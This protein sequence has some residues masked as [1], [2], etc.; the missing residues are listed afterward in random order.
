LLHR[1][2]M[3][4]KIQKNLVQMAIP[5]QYIRLLEYLCNVLRRSDNIQHLRANL[6]CERLVCSSNVVT[7]SHR[8]NQILPAY[9]GHA[10]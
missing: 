10:M 9:A 7:M 2:R 8:I 5:T 6:E 1:L 3:H 4:P